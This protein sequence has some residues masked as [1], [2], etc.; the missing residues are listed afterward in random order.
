[1]VEA[2]GYEVL[3]EGDA[4]VIRFNWLGCPYSPSLEDDPETMARV[5]DAIT[6]VKDVSR[7]VIAEAYEYEYDETQTNMLAE[8]AHT[9][10]ILIKE[11]NIL[12][13]PS[14]TGAECSQYFPEHFKFVEDLLVNKIRKDPIEGYFALLD[15]LRDFEMKVEALQFP[16]MKECY[17]MY[18]KQVLFTIKKYLEQIKIIKKVLPI[19]SRLRPGD[20]VIYGEIFSPTIRPNFTLTRYMLKPPADSELLDSYVLAGDIDV[21]IY[22]IKN[23]TENYYHI[24]PPETAT[25]TFP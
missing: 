3:K 21:E 5:V 4:T 11:E 25:F 14:L 13:N 17:V 22:R 10:E 18:V 9:L 23:Q 15:E 8:L 20:R 24:V 1:M 2:C 16:K 12:A 19:L 6:Q 7:I